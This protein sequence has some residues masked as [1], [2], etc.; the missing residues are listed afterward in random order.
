MMLSTYTVTISNQMG[1]AFLQKNMYLS[2]SNIDVSSL[3]TGVYFI[4]VTNKQGVIK[5]VIFS[6]L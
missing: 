5:S 4:T 6:K 1:K 3:K 2:G